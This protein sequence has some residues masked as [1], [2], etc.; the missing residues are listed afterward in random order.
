MALVS[1]LFGNTLVYQGHG[2][3]LLSFFRDPIVT[4]MGC[5][6]AFPEY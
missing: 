4:N 5:T 6:W 3:N 1:K 2:E